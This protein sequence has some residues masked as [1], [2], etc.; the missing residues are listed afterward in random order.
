M[1]LH[2][3][4]R[5][6]ADEAPAPAVPPGLFDRARRKRRQRWL[7]AAAAVLVL[8]LSGYGVSVIDQHRSHVAAGPD[9]LPSTVA[10]PPRWTKEFAG[11][12]NGPASVVFWG[13]AVSGPAFG[14]GADT[15]T[16]VVGLA[17]D[18]YRVVYP[19]Q[20]SLALSPDG[21]TL[22]LPYLDSST[23]LAAQHW[24]VEALDVV[25]GRSRLFAT[26]ATPDR[27]SADGRHVL[28]VRPDRWDKPDAPAETVNDMTVMVVSWPS[29]QVE[30]SVHIARPAPVEG[31]N[32]YHLALSPD[33][34]MLAVATSGELRVYRRDGTVAWRV[35]QSWVLVGGPA[36]WRDDG[37]LAVIRRSVDSCAGCLPSGWTDP[38][39]WRL[40]FVEAATGRPVQG[41]GYPVLRSAFGAKVIAWRGDTAYVV[42]RF[43]GAGD[44]N[45]A[46]L[47][48]FRPGAA[49]PE[50]V[51]TMPAGASDLTVATDYVDSVRPAGTADFGLSGAQV[52][53]ML[54]DASRP[55][56]AVVVVGVLLW[57]WRRS[58]TR[59]RP[60]PP[61]P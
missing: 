35:V 43:H 31:E 51:L 19:S 26:G 24:R 18:T 42:A 49:A 8:V 33:A 30:W 23:S 2:Q 29:G 4:L 40:E 52:L 20:S 15:P 13:P 28:L 44:D 38:S 39:D 12:P 25:T 36:A 9:G 56:G 17:S 22:L 7:G 32:S 58:R 50:Q 16:A 37:R 10:D 48:R 14:S 61:A 11:S 60:V 57:Y 46:T 53:S 27:W 34:S 59:L 1:N 21:R 45:R 3:M 55:A 47:L 54:V 41:A 5:D 6:L